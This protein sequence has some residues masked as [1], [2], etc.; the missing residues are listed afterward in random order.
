LSG[1]DAVPVAENQQQPTVQAPSAMGSV[2][3]VRVSTDPSIDA[4]QWATQPNKTVHQGSSNAPP[5]F[6]FCRA[7][8]PTIVA[9]SAATDQRPVLAIDDSYYQCSQ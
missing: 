2:N 1:V 3:E 8:K 6:L 7:G 9:R 5:A 4:Q